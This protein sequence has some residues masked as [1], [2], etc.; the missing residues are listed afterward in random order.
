MEAYQSNEWKSV[1][2]NDFVHDFDDSEQYFM[3]ET[4]DFQNF[5]TEFQPTEIQGLIGYPCEDT[6]TQYNQ[7]IEGISMEPQIYNGEETSLHWQNQF[8]VEKPKSLFECKFSTGANTEL[9][10]DR[11]GEVS[12]GI[13]YDNRRTP[14]AR[15]ALV[16]M[17][18]LHNEFLSQTIDSLILEIPPSDFNFLDS[19]DNMSVLK[20]ELLA[21]NFGSTSDAELSNILFQHDF[22]V[23]RLKPSWSYI[24]SKTFKKKL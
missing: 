3:L 7:Q 17:D 14:T 8:E 11:V 20:G 4:K 22:S 9:R 1:N 21:T 24:N 19:K 2:Q 16:G 18:S 13:P 23:E 15:D 12:F 10:T 5:S 6:A